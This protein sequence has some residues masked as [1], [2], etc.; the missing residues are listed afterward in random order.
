MNA[1]KNNYLKR[2]NTAAVILLVKNRRQDCSVKISCKVETR[3]SVND[4]AS[5]YSYDIGLVRI[6]GRVKVSVQ[7][8]RLVLEFLYR[9]VNTIIH[10]ALHL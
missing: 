3:H 8:I 9:K 10:H 2:T 1:C 6:K 4:S 7:V 5:G